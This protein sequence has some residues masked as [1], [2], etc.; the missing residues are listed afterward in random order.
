MKKNLI[1]IHNL[2]YLKKVFPLVRVQI[3]NFDITIIVTGVLLKD[4]LFF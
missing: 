1:I 2:N 4:V 3:Y